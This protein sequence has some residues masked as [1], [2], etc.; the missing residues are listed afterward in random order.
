MPYKLQ[1]LG[2]GGILD[3]SIAIVKDNLGLLFRIL[4]IM[5]IPFNLVFGYIAA[6]I[7]PSTTSFIPSPEQQAETN[8]AMLQYGHSF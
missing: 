8:A 1:Q 3:Q 5:S 2:L 6:T 7:L 4:L